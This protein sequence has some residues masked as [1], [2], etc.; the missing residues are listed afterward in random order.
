MNRLLAKI[1]ALLLTLMVGLIA[2]SSAFATATIVIQNND[3]AG[4]G[5][6]DTTPAA[7]VGGNTGTTVGQQRLIAFQFAANIWGA[8]LVSG[9]TIT[10]NASLSPLT[11]CSAGS[12]VLGS[13]GTHSLIANFP[14][15][16]FLNAWYSVALA[17]A[18]AG[19][20]R[21]GA[22]PEIDA[23]FNSNVGTPGCLTS[24][25]FIGLTDSTVFTKP[26][27]WTW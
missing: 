26:T 18:L 4:V 22:S 1:P 19:N 23:Q 24:S 27:A 6:N 13:A 12:G 20:D 21:N 8:T 3:A 16:V 14:N 25:P 5:F 9:P 17:N 15:A 11:P 10:I 7:P 2:S